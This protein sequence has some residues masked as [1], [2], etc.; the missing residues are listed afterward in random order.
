MSYAEL[1][2]RFSGAFSAGVVASLP[3]VPLSAIGAAY[4]RANALL[5]F[6]FAVF[7]AF[8]GR[9]GPALL[10]WGFAAGIAVY[11]LAV[12]FAPGRLAQALLWGLL[13]LGAAAAIAPGWR[14]GTRSVLDLASSGLVAGSILVTMILGH[15][16]LVVPGLTF[17]HL[18]RMTLIFVGALAARACLEAAPFFFGVPVL[19]GGTGGIDL[20]FRLM[21]CL[22]GIL[23]PGVLSWMVWQCL[24]IKSNQS[25]TGIL[26]AISALVLIGEIASHLLKAL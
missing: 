7:G 22:F 3:W 21:R 10:L 9:G 14:E 1:F 12:S 18:R 17:D 24:K 13:P 25:A 26:Y 6:L 8:L 20:V 16:Y 2:S 4:F 11:A 5:A 23:A 19:A 15:W